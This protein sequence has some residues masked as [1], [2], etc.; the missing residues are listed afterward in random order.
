VHLGHAEQRAR[1]KHGRVRQAAVGGLRRG[2]HGDRGHARGLG[3]DDVH[4]HRGGIR[5][6][7]AGDVHPGPADRDEAAG[8]GETVGDLSGRLGR[9]LRAVH[10]PGAPDGLL[11]RLSH[12]GIEPGQGRVQGPRRH[13]RGGQVDAV[14][15][16]GV[17]AHGLGSAALHVLAVGPDLRDGRLD[18][19]RGAGQETG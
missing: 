4:H 8:D 10:T 15:P 11:Q 5:D 14:E 18:V 3:R 7:A 1:G 16:G 19:G 9:E 13:P 17:L 6:Q 12:L 2:R